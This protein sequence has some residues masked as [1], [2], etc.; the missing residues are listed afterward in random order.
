MKEVIIDFIVKLIIV[1]IGFTLLV[2]ITAL[3]IE[4]IEFLPQY[5]GGFGTFMLYVALFTLL[6]TGL[7]KLNNK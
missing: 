6:F 7:Y 1:I 5:I 4:G 2:G 3:C